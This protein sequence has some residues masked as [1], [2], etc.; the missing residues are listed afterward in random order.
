MAERSQSANA[1]KTLIPYLKSR[2]VGKLDALVLTHTDQD[3]MGDMVEV[4]KQIPVN[5]VYVSP[6]S[7][8]N[9]QFPRENWNSFIARLKWSPERDQ[10]PIFDHHLEVLSPDEV[11][12]AKNNDSIVP[13]GQFYQ[14]RFLFTG[15]LEEAGEK[16]YWKTIHNYK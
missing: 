14:K 15:D 16:N 8:T 11:G 2:G 13:Y 4:A 10:L 9:S 5:K 7:L 6:G 3:H 1:D 12:M